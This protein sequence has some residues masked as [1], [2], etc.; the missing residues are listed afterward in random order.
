MEP[1][2][3]T[4]SPFS[5]F[6][7]ELV[8]LAC[9]VIVAVG[10][11][12]NQAP[13]VAAPPVV[14]KSQQPEL[15]DE[16]FAPSVVR[17]LRGGEVSWR[18]EALAPIV[19]KLLQR[20]QELFRAGHDEAALHATQGA[21][22][23]ARS[24]ELPPAV[25]VGR[26]ETLLRAAA[27][28]ARR[29]DEG[30]ARAFY[31]LARGAAPAGARKREIDA[32]LKA[33]D[34]WQSTTR[35]QGSV[36]AFGRD[37]DALVQQA[38]IERTP[39]TVDAATRAVLAWIDRA[40]RVN[41][42]GPPQTMNELAERNEA[43]L[44][45]RQGVQALVATHLRDGDAA[46]ASAALDVE[47]F[48]F[49]RGLR[50]RLNAA[51]NG[52]AEAWAE[53]FGNYKSQQE[54]RE[55]SAYAD[56]ARGAAWGAAVELLR[57]E[58]RSM[59]AALPVGTLLFEHGMGDVAPSIFSEAIGQ[60]PDP[61]QLNWAL[62]LTLRGLAESERRHQVPLARRIFDN[63][64]P[65]LNLA[66]SDEYV[67]N[68]KT[69]AAD[70]HYMMGAIESRAGELER[71][72]PHLLR[73]LEFESSPD[74]L[75][76]LSAIDRQ[77]GELELA[78]KPL[79][80]RLKLAQS[81]ASLNE[82]A[83]TQLLAF[84]VFREQGDRAR[85][86]EALEQALRAALSSRLKSQSTG[87]QATAERQL[88]AALEHYSEQQAERRAQER[89]REASLND[90]RQLSNVLLEAS[91]RALTGSD[92]QAGRLAVRQA[93]ADDIG[94]EDLTY[95]ALWLKL[96]ELRVN[97]TSDGTVEEALA[98]VAPEDRWVRLL[99]DWGR[100]M[101]SDEALLNKTQ[102]VVQKAEAEFY[103]AS[104]RHFANPTDQTTARLR[105]VAS[106][107]AIELVEVRIARDILR[108]PY[109]ATLPADI[110]LP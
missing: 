62:M 19:R 106:G 45:Q 104:L 6:A 1:P 70:F 35:T 96:L 49:L 16:A 52:E 61:R 50:E 69:G 12:G 42:D 101:L 40:L 11:G 31:R 81:A 38:L 57:A 79:Q 103:V 24:G 4:S 41:W 23:L 102:S 18:A 29:G 67:S 95:A 9:A 33:I 107:T 73:A 109:A 47:T 56:V 48:S 83:F 8:C 80:V 82:V 36:Q 60:R 92:L 99:R 105:S 39:K 94:Q 65:L 27:V 74:V 77:R 68:L 84:D 17:L 46:A 89:A 2:V 54:N 44:A 93:M 26:E 43:R 55:G 13:P 7:S 91:R 88:A 90:V 21:F 10:C 97:A 20:G 64:Q 87:L 22:F 30:Q 15:S 71:A 76:L 86:D 66:A 28:V 5:G 100:G 25:L 75:R 59:R 63:A 32:H 58:P 85:A 78:L 14:A 108:G 110:Q 51:A 34:R 72:R 53:L 37:Q 3:A 98:A